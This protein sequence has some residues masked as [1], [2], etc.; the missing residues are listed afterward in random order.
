MKTDSVIRLENVS[1]KYRLFDSKLHR[2]LEAL[3]PRN[4]AYHREFWALRNVN[5]DVPRRCTLGVLGMNGSGKSTLLQ[6]IASVLQPT[7]GRVTVDGRVAALLELGAGFNRE[8]SAR[9]N[10]IM[11]GT[12]MGLNKSQILARMKDIEAFADIGDFFDQ[13]MKIYSSGMFARVAFAAAVHV[14]PDILIID[15]ALSVGDARFREKCFRKFRSFQE[16]G[17]TVIYV[18]H[19]RSS[20]TRLCDIALLLHEGRL[21]AVGEPRQISDHYDQILAAG[22]R[23]LSSGMHSPMGPEVDGTYEQGQNRRAQQTLS[24]VDDEITRFLACVP[25]TDLCASNPTYNKYEHRFGNGNAKIVD[26]LLCVATAVN[27]QTIDSGATLDIYLKIRFERP[28]NAPVVGLRFTNKEGILIFGTNTSLM[29]IVLPPMDA[30]SVRT[31]RF[32]VAATLAPGDWFIDFAV[33]ESTSDLC[34]CR[35]SL[36]FLQ[37]LDSRRYTGLVALATSFDSVA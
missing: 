32:R 10:V 2:L 8:L 30:E 33:A 5:V 12:I 27:P 15:E 7:E 22:S 13:P 17:R 1:K 24:A 35:N 37:F 16:S 29:D 34:D 3:D 18:T 11:N 6:I 21:L 19:D 31:F 36:V 26:Y 28:I 14:D 20:V 4:K 25:T 23:V 9:E